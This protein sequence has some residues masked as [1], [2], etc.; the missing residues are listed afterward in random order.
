M[1]LPQPT[2]E[3]PIAKTAKIVI[4]T[5]IELLLEVVV[6]KSAR[7]AFSA[8][9]SIVNTPCGPVIDAVLCPACSTA[10]IRLHGESDSEASDSTKKVR[11]AA[12]SVTFFTPR[13][14]CR[15]FEIDCAPSL[16]AIV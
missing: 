5:F 10:A 9:R 15:R 8:D 12:S 6:L 2:I 3:T 1:V 13:T 4:E 7:A 11:L 16:D 14:V